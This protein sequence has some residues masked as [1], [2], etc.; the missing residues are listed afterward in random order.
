MNRLGPNGKA[1][2]V[3]EDAGVAEVLIEVVAEARD[4]RIAESA[5]TVTRLDI[6]RDIVSTLLPA[7]YVR[8]QGIQK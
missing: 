2:V 7:R 6:L 8:S 4:M 3:D 5:T 1:R